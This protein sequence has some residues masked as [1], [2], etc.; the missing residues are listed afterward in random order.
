[1][2]QQAIAAPD[3]PGRPMDIVAGLPIEV[4]ASLQSVRERLAELESWGVSYVRLNCADESALDF[5]SKLISMS[6][7][8]MTSSGV[9]PGATASSAKPSL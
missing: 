8:A 9:K 3:W 5:A 2:I 4:D 7:N 1:M 6:D